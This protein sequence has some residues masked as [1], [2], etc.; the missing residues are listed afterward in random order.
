MATLTPTIHNIMKIKDEDDESGKY[1]EV[2]DKIK[3]EKQ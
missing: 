3:Y 1:G 2:K